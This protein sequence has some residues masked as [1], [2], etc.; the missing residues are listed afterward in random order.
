M[1]SLLASQLGFVPLASIM[2]M[3]SHRSQRVDTHSRLQSGSGQRVLCKSDSA[4]VMAVINTE[5]VANVLTPLRFLLCCILY[6]LSVSVS[7]LPATSQLSPCPFTHSPPRPPLIPSPTGHHDSHA[8]LDIQSLEAAI[9]V[10]D[11]HGAKAV[12]LAAHHP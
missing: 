5:L 4:A 2:V 3:A 11:M 7:H 8:R 12:S 1:W 9:Q 6:Q 10:K